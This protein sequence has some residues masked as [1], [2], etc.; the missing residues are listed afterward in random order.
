MR[1]LIAVA[2]KDAEAI[3]KRKQYAVIP[4]NQERDASQIFFNDISAAALKL[5]ALL[6]DTTATQEERSVLL[7]SL[8]K[9]R[10]KE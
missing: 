10:T 1:Y 2:Q 8:L 9:Q 4:T 7:L 6:N 5:H 3:K